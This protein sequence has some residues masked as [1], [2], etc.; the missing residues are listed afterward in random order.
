MIETEKAMS[1]VIPCYNAEK[2][3]SACVNSV[4]KQTVKPDEILVIDDGSTDRTSSIVGKLPI[5]LI[6]HNKNKGI[7]A[8]RNTGL[9]FAK[10]SIVAFL[11]SDC[12]M[13][14]DCLKF[15][16]ED[17][18][19]GVTGVEG[20]GCELYTR[21]PLQ[22]YRILFHVQTERK[23]SKYPNVIATLCTAFKKQTILN[24]GGF[25]EFYKNCG[26]D[27]DLSLRLTRKGHLLLYDPRIYAWHAKYETFRSFRKN[28][29]NRYFYGE[30]A[31]TMNMAVSVRRMVR[32]A[33][34]ILFRGFYRAKRGIRDREHPF[35]LVV[36]SF[37]EIVPQLLA[38][39]SIVK[40][41]KRGGVKYT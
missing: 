5:R 32:E 4:L 2:T 22:R 23:T 36:L 39:N 7:G 8:A 1:V 25:N 16:K 27:I 11:D 20:Q 18:K 15:F 10:G 6:S 37:V 30:L 19:D 24:I 17:F 35:A 21:G 26:E 34:K 28:A 3:I 14:K 29:Y 40:V 9:N 31:N 13:S 33:Y 41:L 12:I 38:L